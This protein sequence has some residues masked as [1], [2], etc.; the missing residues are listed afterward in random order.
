MEAG[1]SELPIPERDDRVALYLSVGIAAIG[2]VA[3]LVT[4]VARLVEVAPATDIPVRIPLD[5]E[6]VEL[7]LG[8][9]GTPVWATVD[10]ATVTVANPAPATLFALWAQPIWLALA[11]LAGLALASLFFL[12]VARGE[13]FTRGAARLPLAAATVVGAGWLGSTVLTNMT[14]NGALAAVSDGTY[15]SVTFTISMVPFFAILLLGGLGAALQIGEKLQRDTAG[16][17]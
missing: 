12:R 2:A 14:T 13:I 3:T 10:T 11:V 15:E 8:P 6:H 16:L 4:T 1:M 5:G 17:V 7:P 9:D